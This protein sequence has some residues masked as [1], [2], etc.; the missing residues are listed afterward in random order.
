V[1]NYLKHVCKYKV[2][3]KAVYSK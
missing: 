3:E 2:K 1:L